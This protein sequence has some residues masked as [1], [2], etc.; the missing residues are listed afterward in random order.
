MDYYEFVCV[1]R[2]S[3]FVATGDPNP[4]HIPGAALACAKQW[5]LKRSFRLGD[6]SHAAAVDAAIQVRVA[7]EGYHI[8]VNRPAASPAMAFRQRTQ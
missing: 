5:R 2:P 7:G 3:L 6:G 4:A 1:G 8:F